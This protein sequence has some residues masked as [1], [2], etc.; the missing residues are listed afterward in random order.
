MPANAVMTDGMSIS[1]TT[2]NSRLLMS[3]GAIVKLI[4]GIVPTVDE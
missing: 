2:D 3:G 1:T 4:A